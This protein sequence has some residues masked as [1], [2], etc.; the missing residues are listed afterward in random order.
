M[1]GATGAERNHGVNAHT[2]YHE[3]AYKINLPNSESFDTAMLWLR[4]VASRITFSTKEVEQEK[5]ILLS[6]NRY[7]SPEHQP[8]SDKYYDFLIKGSVQLKGRQ[9]EHRKLFRLLRL[10]R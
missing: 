2:G 10:I 9:A 8:F 4:D 6:E 3:T 1:I 5:N 7:R